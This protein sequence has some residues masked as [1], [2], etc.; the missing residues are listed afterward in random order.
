LQ[1]AYHINRFRRVFWQSRLGFSWDLPLGPGFNRSSPAVVVTIKDEDAGLQAYGGAVSNAIYLDLL[2]HRG[3]EADIIYHEMTHLLIADRLVEIDSSG[4]PRLGRGDGDTRGDE[5]AAMDEGLAD[6]F[7]AS[8]TNDPVIARCNAWYIYPYDSDRCFPGAQP[9]RNLEVRKMYPWP[10]PYRHDEY[11][12][13]PIF[14]GALWELRRRIDGPNASEAWET[15]RLVKHALDY[16]I[17]ENS[18]PH[19]TYRFTD[20]YDALIAVDGQLSQKAHGPAITEA[21]ELHN[22]INP[23]PHTILETLISSVVPQPAEI[24]IGWPFNRR[25][26]GY[27]VLRSTVDYN[28]FAG[29]GG[30]VS[31]SPELT[32]TTFTYLNRDPRV[33]YLFSV[34]A[35]DSSGQD[36]YLSPPVFVAA[37]DT[38]VTGVSE[39]RLTSSRRGRFLFS[40]PNPFNPETQ[41]TFEV[42]SHDVVGIRIYNAGGQ[43]VTTLPTQ[44]YSP[45]RHS[46]K[47]SGR[48]HR[49]QKVASGA[50]Y[51]AIAGAGWQDRGKIILLK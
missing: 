5:G 29:L 3:E 8:F 6:Y 24:I 51:L 38:T 27:Q 39:N 25:A 14:A 18:D 33:E 17:T 23:V 40:S 46:V 26:R 19:P 12:G 11:A 43:L 10:L 50:Y 35:I 21:F 32:D 34:V 15:D 13:A 9:L 20:F 1:V 44:R 48:D 49:A 22:M 2:Q 41:I 31:V 30:F 37:L 16:M 42:T 45:G 28:G 7:A 36:G 4:T 47:W